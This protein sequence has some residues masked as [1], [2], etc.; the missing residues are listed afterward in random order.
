[1]AVLYKSTLQKYDV[2]RFLRPKM[3]IVRSRDDDVY[4]YGLLRILYAAVAA[5]S[6][7]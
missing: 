2:T 3:M 5:Q 7:E 6:A 4:V 1:M